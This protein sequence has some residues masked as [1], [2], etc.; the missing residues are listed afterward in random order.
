M[1]NKFWQ[2]DHLAAQKQGNTALIMLDNLQFDNA[3]VER[4]V[5][6][7]ELNELVTKAKQQIRKQLSMYL[8]NKQ[9]LMLVA[10]YSINSIVYYLAALQLK[11]VVWWVDK[12]LSTEQ[13][14]N[15][16]AHYQV[17]FIDKRWKYNPTWRI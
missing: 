3:A 9:L 15:L 13:R 17:N 2:S 8:A 1:N 7:F 14:Q 12:D 6:Y 4:K 11:Q 10:H 16:C 5:S